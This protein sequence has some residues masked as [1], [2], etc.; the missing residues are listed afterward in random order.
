MQTE[1]LGERYQLQGPIGRGGMATI[2]RGHDKHM[3]RTVA[4]KVLRDVYSTDP[5]FVMRFE[6][7]AKSASALQHPNIVQVY[8]YGYSEG[9]YYIVME[10]IEGSDLRRYLRSRAVLDIDRAIIIAHDIALG[11]GAAHRRGIVHRDVKPQNILVGRDGS[12][13]LTDFGIAS[14]YK[15]I[16][17]ER[18]TTTGMTLGTVQYYAPEQAQGEIVN[19]AA[20]VYALGIVMYEMLTGRPP[21]DGDSPVAVAMQHIQD[22]PTPPSQLNPNIPPALE[23]IILRCLEKVPELRFPDG[24][25]LARALEGLSD[26]RAGVIDSPLPNLG[27]KPGQSPV[28]VMLSKESAPPAHAGTSR[29]PISSP[30][31]GD[32]SNHN[33]LNNIYDASTRVG[34]Q[35]YSKQSM[36]EWDTR[37]PWQRGAIPPVGIVPRSRRDSR[38]AN[39]ITAV[40]LLA[41]LVLLGF[42]VYLA[43]A[44]GIISSPFSPPAQISV[45]NLIGLSYQDAQSTTMNAGFQLQ[46]DNNLTTG[47]VMSQSPK[48]PEKALR[49]STITVK[50]QT[51]QAALTVPNDLVGNSL[52]AAQSALDQAHIQYI[53]LP[54]N[55]PTDPTKGP[56]IVVKVNPVSGTPLNSG[57][58]V[59]VTLYV[60]NLTNGTPTAVPTPSPTPTPT[61]TPTPTPTPTPK[62]A[63]LTVGSFIPSGSKPTVGTIRIENTGAASSSLDWKATLTSSN[64]NIMLSPSSMEGTGLQGGTHKTLRV[65]VAPGTVGVIMATVTITATD[66]NSGN[67]VGSPQTVSITVT[68]V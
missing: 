9:N 13:K 63:V 2:Y 34:Q 49:G 68:V 20:D 26:S 45:P 5:K 42:G 17:A 67:P 7:E 61:A 51:G 15:D 37:Q 60:V 62:P 54:A 6:R 27:T 40:I 55:P 66:S 14:V 39:T 4:I 44:L 48:P 3:G 47:T 29:P 25:S 33:G 22:A 10:L 28:P 12:I 46:A 19:P 41:T 38:F 65:N 30:N 18:L 64:P 11:L 58:G 31:N 24:S 36:P 8:D 50:L 16:N 57:T 23:E 53:I 32:G 43:T 59:K 56:N 35:A 21:F 1:V 52:A